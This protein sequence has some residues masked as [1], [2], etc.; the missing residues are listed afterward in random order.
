MSVARRAVLLGASLAAAASGVEAAVRRRRR[1]L[2]EPQVF[3]LAYHDVSAPDVTAAVGV[4]TAVL[5]PDPAEP[6][7]VISADRLRHQLRYLKRHYRFASLSQAAARLARPGA[8]EED[9]VVVTFDDGYAGNF[10]AALPVLRR[11]QVPATVFVTTGF[12]DGGG[13]WFDLARRLLGAALAAGRELP[14]RQ[15][16]ALQA[17]FGK[18]PGRARRVEWAVERLKRLAPEARQRLLDELAAA[19]LPLGPPARP[20]SWNQV[21]TLAATGIEIGSH[22]VSHPILSQLPPALQAAEIAGSRDRLREE[23][24]E[25]PTAFAYPNGAAED[26][27]ADT[28]KAL[29]DTG[30]TVACTTLRGANR[31]GCDL[32][33]LRRIG[34]G[35]DPGFVLAARLSGLFDDAIRHLL[36]PAPEEAR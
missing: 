36:H 10:E 33:R 13:L 15:R 5:Y 23:L 8:L 26:F 19:D 7:G 3:V 12:L 21:R 16:R 17:A 28:C 2:G 20:M 35:R 9:L 4:P 30:F 32:L 18:W 34:V 27:T 6:E 11:E 31:P 25:A 29:R 14:E 22:T 24:G 1:R